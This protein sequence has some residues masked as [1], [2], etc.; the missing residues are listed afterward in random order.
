MR[1]ILAVAIAGVMSSAAM[2]FESF[3]AESAF[4][5]DLI[6]CPAP[7]VTRTPGLPDLWGC[8]LP[9]ADVV[10][11]FINAD[12]AGGVENVK[13]MWNDWTKDNGYGVHTDKAMALAWLAAIATRYAPESVDQVLAAYEGGNQVSVDGPGHVLAYTYWRGPAIDERLFTITAR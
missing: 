8:I 13:V 1:L 10:K 9:G 7:K 5:S 3:E 12:E 6:K 11:V 4:V 2:A